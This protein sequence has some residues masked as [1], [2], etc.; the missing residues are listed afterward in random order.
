MFSLNQ[1]MSQIT[2]SALELLGRASDILELRSHLAS[3]PSSQNNLAS[4]L[5]NVKKIWVD[6][7]SFLNPRPN[8]SNRNDSVTKIHLFISK[9]PNSDII[10][11]IDHTLTPSYHKGLISIL[12]NSICTI[13]HDSLQDVRRLWEIDVG[14]EI[15]DDIW[16]TVIKLVRS[17]S[18]CARLIQLK[19]VMRPHLTNAGLAKI[20]L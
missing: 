2:I 16:E 9:H 15:T 19:I 5:K 3:L 6:G 11:I 14:R 20:F 1:S 13:T 10:N 8:W 18:L 12:Y 7:P 17:S 4:Y